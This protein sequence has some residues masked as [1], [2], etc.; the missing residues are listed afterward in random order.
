MHFF[1]LRSDMMDV[2]DRA[3]GDVHVPNIRSYTFQL[4]V[5]HPVTCLP[6]FVEFFSHVTSCSP[7]SHPPC[8]HLTYAH[9]HV[10]L[11]IF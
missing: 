1:F 8:M 4:K 11:L 6:Q 2:S 9:T 7:T 5:S 3:F 10:P